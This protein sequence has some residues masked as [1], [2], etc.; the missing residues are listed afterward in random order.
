MNDAFFL[1]SLGL[2]SVLFLFD[3]LFVMAA[4][5]HTMIRG[6]SVQIVFG[7]EVRCSEGRPL[8]FRESPL[9]CYSAGFG[10]LHGYQI[11]SS[12]H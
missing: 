3:H 10:S 9:V 2:L 6:A 5:S 12:R 11:C 8:P 1:S 7:F 4:Y